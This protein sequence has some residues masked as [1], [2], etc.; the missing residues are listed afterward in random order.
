[1]DVQGTVEVVSW[2]LGFG[3]KATVLEPPALRAEVAGEVQRAPRN[4][5]LFT[6]SPV[7]DRKRGH[8]GY[9]EETMADNDNQGNQKQEAAGNDDEVGE[10]NRDADRRYRDATQEYVKSGR[11]DAA[12]K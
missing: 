2:V 1:M 5:Q 10:G 9:T 8:S 4:Y 3:D 12:G 6:V 11:P 7:L